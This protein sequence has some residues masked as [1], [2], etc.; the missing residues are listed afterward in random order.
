MLSSS[1]IF[2][3]QGKESFLYFFLFLKTYFP[4]ISSAQSPEN[5]AL[6]YCLTFLHNKRREGSM[7]PIAGRSLA[8]I[9]SFRESVK[10]SVLMLIFECSVCKKSEASLDHFA[11]VLN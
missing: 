11:S 10:L 4:K 2:A 8:S 9:D 3:N 6:V 7:S 1:S 5:E